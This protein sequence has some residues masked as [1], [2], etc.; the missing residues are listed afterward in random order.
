MQILNAPPREHLTVAQVTNLLQSHSLEVDFG[1]E[2]LSPDLTLREDIS[3]DLENGQIQRNSN[4]NIHGTCS[5]RL[6]RALRWGVDLVR[7]YMVLT[8]G[9]VTARWNVGV[10]C[11]TTPDRAVGEE[12]VTYEA[13]GFDRL[14]LLQRQIGANYS[15]AAG[16]T[17]RQA[18]LDVFTAAGLS[19]VAIDGAAADNTLPAAKSW[20]LVADRAA[21]PDQTDTPVTYLRVVNDLLRAINFRAVWCDENGIFRCSAYQDPKVRP[22]EFVFDADS[23]VTIVGEDRRVME[24][25]WGT[26][27]RWV[28][29]QT[30]R[31]AGAPAPTEGDGIYTT[32]NQSDGITSIDQRGL[33]WTSVVDYEAATQAKLVD[34]GNRRVAID[35]QLTTRF[36]VTTGPF[37]AAAHFDVVTLS[38]SAGGGTRKVQATGWSYS[39]DG[40]DVSWQMEA[41]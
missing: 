39:L 19:G 26:P 36:E 15:V 7:P 21:D 1:A 35:R 37:P 28:F 4:A 16:V 5:L 14:M 40:G 25:V 17:Y 23:A 3:A 2:L 11:L 12:P 18:L 9:S 22:V 34:L 38:D 30:N 6:T 20:P 29:R 41:V 33:T 13:Q 32:V 31:P 10:F 24:D 8:D 27:N